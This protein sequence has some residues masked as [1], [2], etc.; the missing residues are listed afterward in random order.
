MAAKADTSNHKSLKNVTNIN[1]H[2]SQISQKN[3]IIKKQM[4]ELKA[5]EYKDVGNIIEPNG[6]ITIIIYYT[7]VEFVPTIGSSVRANVSAC[8]NTGLKLSYNN[9]TLMCTASKM[10]ETGFTFNSDN[11]TWE[12]KKIDSSPNRNREGPPSIIENNKVYTVYFTKISDSAIL[13]S[14]VQ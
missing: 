12:N 13:V 1:I 6:T 2:P 9:K 4:D 8:G 14:F 3:A 10:K 7:T 11:S 5:T